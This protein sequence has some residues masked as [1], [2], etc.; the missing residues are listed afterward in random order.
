M[1]AQKATQ[2]CL[3]GQGSFLKNKEGRAKWRKADREKQQCAHRLKAEMSCIR[4]QNGHRKAGL[5]EDWS[6]SMTSADC[7]PLPVRGSSSRASP[8]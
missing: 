2:L 7:E 8:I 3:E 1:G 6:F 4:N 5:E